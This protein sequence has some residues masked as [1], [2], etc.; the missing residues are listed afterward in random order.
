MPV[1]VARAMG[2]DVVIAVDISTDYKSEEDFTGLFAVADQLSN[3]LVRRSTQEQAETLSGDDVYIRPD[4]G[5]METVEFE[6][7]P[8]AFKAG[9]EI[10]RGLK[11]KLE[12]LSVSNAEYQKYIEHKQDMRRTLSMAMSVLSTKSFL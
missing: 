7:M 4:V 8:D 12:G 10:T 5:Q 3:Y 1:D 2:A 11:S 9:Y 6:K